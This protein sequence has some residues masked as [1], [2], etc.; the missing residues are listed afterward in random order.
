MNVSSRINWIDA[1]RGLCMFCVMLHH[2]G[3]CPVVFEWLLA[4]FFLFLF[5]FISGFLF[6]ESSFKDSIKRII[7]GLVI[8]Y[9]FLGLLTYF[10]HRITLI[11]IYNGN[12]NVILQG[13]FSLISGSLLWFI[14]CLILVQFVYLLL[15]KL[16][17]KK[18]NIGFKF[19]VGCIMLGSIFLIRN[20][21]RTYLYWNADTALYALGFFVFGHLVKLSNIDLSSLLKNKSFA[22]LNLLIYSIL[23]ILINK[24]VGGLD[25]NVHCNHYNYPLL[26]VLLSCL[27]TFSIIFLTVAFNIGK[28]FLLLGRNSLL[29]FAFHGRGF[30][31]TSKLF[32]LTGITKILG[33]N[34]YIYS[35]LYCFFTG[36]CMILLAFVVNKYVPWLV[37]RKKLI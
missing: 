15:N 8:P 36:V 33:E 37:G 31:I 34:I 6:R 3:Y 11:E 18:I 17:L 35:I 10:T 13:V 26:C 27:G 28:F 32:A 1:S 29:V 20:D 14:P 12:Y 16:L 24:D 25:I 9:V 23:T 4:P 7:N 2:S 22:L 21:S 30:W 19:F 5:F